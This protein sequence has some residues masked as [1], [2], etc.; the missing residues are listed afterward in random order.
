M[1]HVGVECTWRSFGSSWPWLYRHPT[2][3]VNVFQNGVEDLCRSLFVLQVLPRQRIATTSGLGVIRLRSIALVTTCPIAYFEEKIQELNDHHGVLFKGFGK[4]HDGHF[5]GSRFDLAHGYMMQ[6]KCIIRKC[7]CLRRGETGAGRT[8]KLILPIVCLFLLLGIL[9]FTAL[10][11]VLGGEGGR[12]R[13][14][15]GC[16]LAGL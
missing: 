7:S 6:V 1:C 4:I 15:S 11:L 14:G 12:L 8:K 13:A 10:V 16:S 2:Y 5:K 9:I 3:R